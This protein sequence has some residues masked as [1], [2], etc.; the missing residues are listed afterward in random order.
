MLGSKIAQQ[1][2]TLKVTENPTL[3]GN[4][5]GTSLVFLSVTE[6]DSAKKN[7]TAANGDTCLWLPN[8]EV[9][10]YTGPKME[11]SKGIMFIMHMGWVRRK[12]LAELWPVSNPKTT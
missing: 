8:L 9:R 10:L 4:P 11:N 2:Y 1:G 12:R 5:F 6:I 3:P 7:W